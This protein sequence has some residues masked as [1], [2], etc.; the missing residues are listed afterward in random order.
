M[1]RLLLAAMAA[2]LL[3]PALI[4]GAD[5][6]REPGSGQQSVPVANAGEQAARGAYLAR[7]G[8]CMSCHTARGGEAYAGGRPIAT[9]FGNIYTSNLTPDAETGLGKWSQDDFW[10]AIHNGKSRDG[11]FLYPAFPYPNYT[12]VTRADAD[13]MYAYFRTLAPVRQ[14]N[15][16]HELRFPYNQR[17]LLPL[18]RALYFNPGEYQ[19]EASKSAQWNRGAY[20]V[21]GLG[22]CSACHTSRNALGGSIAEHAL[23]GGMIPMQNWYAS[24]L[25]SDAGAGLGEWDVADISALLKTGASQR[26]AVFGPMAEVVGASLQHLSGADIASMAVYLKS[27]PGSQARAAARPAQAAG[28][29][30]AIL[31]QGAV[32]YEKQCASCHGA[33]GR[34]APAAYPPLAGNRSLALPAAT[35]A[36]RMVLNGGYPP[37]TEGNPRPYGM[38]PFGP[39]LSDH[40]VAAVV[41]YIRTSWGNQG[42]PVSSVDVARLR[43]APMD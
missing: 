19:P 37:S 2:V 31:R 28:D 36:I 43:G 7:A 33:D 32:L 22:H 29:A 42:A 30:E 3:V 39:V 15:R 21:Q 35:N 13:A 23:G 4:I 5:H 20:L 16:E 41:S 27:V 10:R 6:L 34:G 40:E 8:N 18:W 17:M 25:T 11:S 9:P 12:R 1:K 24:A 14:P 38:P 26:G